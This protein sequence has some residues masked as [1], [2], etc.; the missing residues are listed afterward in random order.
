MRPTLTLML[1]ALLLHACGPM[2]QMQKVESQIPMI[3]SIGK[4]HS[5]LF[6]KD[7]QKVGEPNLTLPVELSLQSHPFT[8]N[9]LSK[10][11][12]FKESQGMEPLVLVKDTTKVHMPHYFEL[13]ITD[14][15]GL[16]E[17]LNGTDNLRVKKY[18]QEDVELVLLSRLFFV[19]NDEVAKSIKKTDR[20]YLISDSNGVLELM[21]DSDNSIETADLETFDFETANFCWNKDKRDHLEVAHILMDGGSCPG[22]TENDPKKL[23]KTPDYLKL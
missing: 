1:L 19:T 13:T 4:Q 18:L 10:Y 21:S 16:T 15:V 12:K 23:N 6:K 17:Q 8:S 9:M 3:G 7:F 22:S 5:K 11:N 2:R 14:V 20:F